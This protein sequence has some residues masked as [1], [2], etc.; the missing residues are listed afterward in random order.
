M[1]ATLSAAQIAWY[2]TGGNVKFGST[3]GTNMPITPRN[4]QIAI[5]VALAE[6]GGVVDKK[7][8][9]NSDGSFD[10]GLW[11]I[12]DKAHYVS[13]L[14]KTNG[15][16]NWS[17]AYLISRRGTDWTPWTTFKSGKYL[18]FM[19]QAQTG[20]DHPDG[21]YQDQ[22]EVPNNPASAAASVASSLL[23]DALTKASTWIRV[24]EILAGIVLLGLVAA[25]VVGP[26]ALRMV[27]ATRALEAVGSSVRR[28]HGA[29]T[30]A[31]KESVRTV[32]PKGGTQ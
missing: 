26:K 12:N 15:G 21:S 30:S 2:V 31:V 1:G 13:D 27:P 16:A 18:Q 5:A 25:A 24:G 9:P 11:Q 6:S 3:Y 19:Q 10:W 29:T 7:G 17:Q 22:H 23:P 28:A 32:F 8:G 4:A 14:V 20:L